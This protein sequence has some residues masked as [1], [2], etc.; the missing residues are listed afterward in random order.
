MLLRDDQWVRIEKLLQGKAGDRGRSGVNNRLFVEAVLWVARTGS[1]WRD[2]PVEFGSWNSTYVRFA[3]WADKDVWHNI[4]AALRENVDLKKSLLTAPSCGL[5]S[6]LPGL[7]K[8]RGPGSGTFSRRVDNQDP[9][10]RRGARPTG[11]IHANRRT[12]PRCHTGP[13]TDRAN[14]AGG[15]PGGQSRGGTG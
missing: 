3:R 5:I 11:A 14:P 2:L 12:G 8:K 10:L 13:D 7:P 15:G 9:C 6:T 4:F 1:P